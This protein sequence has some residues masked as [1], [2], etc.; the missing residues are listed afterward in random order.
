MLAESQW[1]QLKQ[2][3]RTYCVETESSNYD[4][5]QQEYFG[6]ESDAMQ[7]GY[8][9]GYQDGKKDTHDSIREE[10]SKL[11]LLDEITKETQ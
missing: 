8:D 2:L 7:A 9:C 11:G 4:E 1:S 6:N 10:L 5:V 3:L